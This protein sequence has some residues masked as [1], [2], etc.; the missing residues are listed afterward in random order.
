VFELVSHS[1]FGFWI[2]AALV[3]VFDATLFLVPGNLTFTFGTRLN[4][5]LRIIENPYLLRH[6]EAIIT[7]FAHPLT[8]FFI[9]SVNVP[10]KGRA[11]TK[12]ILLGQ[13]RVAHNSR[14]LTLLAL[15]SLLLLSVVGP[16][17][18]LQY[19]IER[20]LFMVVPALYVSA[21]SG[22]LVVHLNRSLFGFGGRDLAYI[23]FE[24]L[25]CPI[26]LVNIFKRIALK[27]SI[28]CT[29]D[30]INDFCEDQAATIKRLAEYAE[31][32]E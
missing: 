28:P 1:P 8:P 22:A 16:P 14:Q 5:R 25:V 2:I 9:S 32:T 19:G 3:I 11:A 18:S 7:L 30:L 10:S 27:Q 6:K 4:V 24:L 20:A 21:L 15:L 17:A 13:R 26:L 12:R 31:A 29:A 23:Y